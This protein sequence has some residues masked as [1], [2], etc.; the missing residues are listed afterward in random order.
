MLTPN[1]HQKV[2]TSGRDI[3]LYCDLESY[4][5]AV[6]HWTFNG[7]A[8]FEPQLLSQRKSTNSQWRLNSDDSSSVRVARSSSLVQLNSQQQLELDNSESDDK[9]DMSIIDDVD[10]YNYKSILMLKIKDFQQTDY[11]VYICVSIHI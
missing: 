9:Y 4:P 2:K 7:Q 8:L 11:G 1:K 5:K 10:N 6:A 3:V